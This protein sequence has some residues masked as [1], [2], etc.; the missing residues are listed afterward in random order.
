VAVSGEATVRLQL[1]QTTAHQ[2]AFL[3]E[4]RV[5][6][7]EHA[8]SGP[9]IGLAMPRPSASCARDART[10]LE[11]EIQRILRSRPSSRCRETICA[12][13]RTLGIESDASELAVIPWQVTFDPEITEREI[14]RSRG[15][16]SEA[17]PVTYRLQARRA[18]TP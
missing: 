16:G 5:I 8:V 7:D 12:H 2:L 1:D 18:D 15:S 10:Q 11:A 4:P 9:A 17:P 14:A 3:I 13:L 6:A